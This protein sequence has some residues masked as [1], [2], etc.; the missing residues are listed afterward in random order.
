[1]KIGIICHP[2]IG[3]SGLVATQLGIGLA[4]RG[5]E[6]HFISR[7]MPFK[8]SGKEPNIHFHPVEPVYYPLFDD[9]LY[10][11]SLTAK[12]VEVAEKHDL[13]I[14]HAHY[15]IPHS[16]CVHLA[17]EISSKDFRTITTIHG[18]DSTL[19]GRDKPLFPLNRFSI[20]QSDVVTTVSRYQRQ[21]IREGFGLEREIEVI[22]NFI[23]PQSFRPELATLET[24]R[25]LAPDDEKIIMHVSNFR[26]P[27]NTQGVVKTFALAAAKVKARLVLIG[28]GP[29]M[30]EVKSLCHKLKVWNRVMF[31]GNMNHIE[32]LIPNADCVLQP[33]YIDS[34]GM[35][36]LEAMA[37]GVPTV[38]SNR[39]GIPEVVKHGETGYTADPDDH[40][41]LANY[42]V[43]VCRDQKLQDNLGENG[44][45]RAIEHFLWSRQIDRYLQCY[46]RCLDQH[47][48][49]R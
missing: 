24:R 35:V 42:L 18:T 11:F 27:K 6:V 33:S 12:I 22:Y 30:D 34:F 36:A 26:K 21:N 47:S 43:A 10:T 15:S 44:R 1:M 41:A 25:T 8:L 16:L 48:I 19:L 31:L 49:N 38:A 23:D 2:S 45:T 5:H 7:A 40:D 39:D 17:R 4:Q 37:S 46:Q 13:A 20:N 28:D 9:R 32:A 14:M 29:D 3:G